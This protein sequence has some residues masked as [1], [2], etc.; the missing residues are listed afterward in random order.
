[1]KARE[2]LNKQ[3]EARNGAS[4]GML[5]LRQVAAPAAD[6]EETQEQLIAD[7]MPHQ[8]HIPAQ[9][10]KPKDEELQRLDDALTVVKQRTGVDLTGAPMLI[11]K[12][13]HPALD[14]GIQGLRAA[15]G[16]VD[17]K[18]GETEKKPE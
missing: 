4:E 16:F 10:Y 15:S 1:M 17:M 9:A 2:E 7:I 6:E 13:V 5:K 3:I 14:L 8:E 18:E 12:M 11:E